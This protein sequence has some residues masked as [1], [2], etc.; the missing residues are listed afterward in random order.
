[1]PEPTAM[2]N[3]EGRIAALEAENTDEAEFINNTV[4]R[5]LDDMSRRLQTVERKTHSMSDRP[6][7]QNCPHCGKLVNNPRATHCPLCNKKL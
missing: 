5:R 6:P 4:L 3:L 1:M 7:Q 2:E